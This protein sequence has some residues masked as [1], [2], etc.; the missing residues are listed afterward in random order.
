LLCE[1]I[2]VMAGSAPE[3]KIARFLSELRSDTQT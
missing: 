3:L 1:Y 2:V